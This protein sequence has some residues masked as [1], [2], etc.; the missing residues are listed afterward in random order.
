[1]T[2]HPRALD[3]PQSFLSSVIPDEAELTAGQRVEPGR[4]YGFFT[5]T[6]L[7][8]ITVLIPSPRCSDSSTS[9][10]TYRRTGPEN[11]PARGPAIRPEISP[12]PGYAR[13]ARVPPPSRRDC[14]S[15][16]RARR[17]AL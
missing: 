15:P 3:Y 6:T 14:V 17:A 2:V 8:I 16:V 13:P 5:D 7:C 1:M 11:S 9:S 4:S 10:S 12:F